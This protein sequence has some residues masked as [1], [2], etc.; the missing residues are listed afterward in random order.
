MSADTYTPTSMQDRGDAIYFKDGS[1]DARIIPKSDTLAGVYLKRLNKVVGGELAGLEEGSEVTTPE[2]IKDYQIE[3]DITSPELLS[4]HTNFKKII[5][6]SADKL[7]EILSVSLAMLSSDVAYLDPSN[8]ELVIAYGDTSG[9]IAARV[10][11]TDLVT[12]LSDNLVEINPAIIG[13][14]SKTLADLINIPMV[15]YLTHA[16]TTGTGAIKVFIR[17]KLVG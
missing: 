17:Y 7:I 15:M 16:I 14:T 6:A 1:G 3:F 10:P 11:V 2:E 13:D 9:A 12:A 5:P 8:A 4:L